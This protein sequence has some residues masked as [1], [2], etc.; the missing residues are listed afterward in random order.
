M[1]T[2][3]HGLLKKQAMAQ[4]MKRTLRS[5]SPSLHPLHFHAPSP[6]AACLSG[7]SFAHGVWVATDRQTVSV[8]VSACQRVSGSIG[9]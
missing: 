4:W 8:S 1:K 9:G 5:E 3:S 7:K 2:V 6:P